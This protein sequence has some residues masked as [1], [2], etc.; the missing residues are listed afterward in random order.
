MIRE[1]LTDNPSLGVSKTMDILRKKNVEASLNSK[2]IPLHYDQVKKIIRSYKEE[3]NLSST[4]MLD[5]KMLLTIDG[6]PLR[7]CHIKLDLIYKSKILSLI[8][9]K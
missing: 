6:A 7:R 3:N 1:A 9:S 2:K 8:F 4:R 5:D